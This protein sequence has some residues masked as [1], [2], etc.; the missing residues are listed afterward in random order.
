VL[1][2]TYSYAAS[3]QVTG[4]TGAAFTYSNS[5]RLASVTTSGGATYYVLNALGQRVKKYWTAG[6]EYFVYDEAGH[7]LGEYDGS[8]N[9]IQETVWM[10]DI[11][12]ATL[13]PNG[14]GGINLYYIHTDNLNAPRRISRPSDNVI[15]WRWDSDPFGTTAANQD[16]DADGV[17]FTYNARFPGQYYDVESGLNYNYFRDYDPQVGNYIESDPIGQRGGLNTYAYVNGNPLSLLDPFGLCVNRQRCEQLR[18]AIDGRDKALANKL[19]KY[20]PKADAVGGFPYFGGIRITQPGTHYAAIQSM[21]LNQA[22]DLAEYA[23]LLCDQDDDQGPGLG[24]IA[25][26]ILDRATQPVPPPDWA[27]VPA[28]PS[29]S[30]PNQTT[31]AAALS[32]LAALAAAAALAL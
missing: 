20:D 23:R 18:K 31:L 8:G 13:Q 11:P 30:S 24:A 19:A 2:R 1:S 21:Q 5:G 4:Y 26:E 7:L 3:G 32:A 14:S 22:R 16:P 28:A 12:V 15:V 29:L 6:A 27:S 10:G 25:N 9:L 17:S